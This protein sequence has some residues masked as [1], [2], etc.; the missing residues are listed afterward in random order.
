MEAWGDETGQVF[1]RSE[2]REAQPGKLVTARVD[3]ILL[4]PMDD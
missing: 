3:P 2:P 1:L 4:S